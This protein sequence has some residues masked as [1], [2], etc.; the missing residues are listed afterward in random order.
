MIKKKLSMILCSAFIALFLGGEVN[1][2]AY[3]N[4]P[5][6]IKR[7]SLL[8]STSTV[9]NNLSEA[10]KSYIRNQLY[11]LNEEFSLDQF[12]IPYSYDNANK[13]LDTIV[14]TT[15]IEYLYDTQLMYYSYGGYIGKI[16]LKRKY[17][18]QTSLT[19][20]SQFESK[21]NEIINKYIKPEMSDLEKEVV[22]HNYLV[23]N[24]VYDESDPNTAHNAYGALIKGLAVCDGYSKA[25]KYFMDRFGIE[26]G[27]VLS[28][29][30]AHAWNYIKIDGV[31]YFVDTTWDDPVSN[32]AKGYKDNL[33]YFNVTQSKLLEDHVWDTNKYPQAGD[34]RFNYLNTLNV[35]GRFGGK[36]FYYYDRSQNKIWSIDE[37]TGAKKSFSVNGSVDNFYVYNDVIVYGN[38]YGGIRTINTLT[39]ED[40]PLIEG[41]NIY[42]KSI[43]N[44]ILNYES[45][46]GEK[47]LSLI[48]L[49]R[50]N[51]V[52][53]GINSNIDVIYQS[54][55]QNIGWQDEISNGAMSGTEGYSLRV[56]ALK[57][58][59][60]NS[61]PSGLKIKYRTH[62]QNVGWQDWVYD[63]N[64]AGTTGQS[65]RI[66]AVEIKLE[67]TDADKY[68][69]K[70]QAHVQNEG[71]QDWVSD[72]QTAGTTGKSERVEALRVVI[73]KKS[74]VANSSENTL[75]NYSNLSSDLDI[76]YKTHVQNIGWQ[77]YVANGN[78][79]GTEGQSLR[80]EAINVVLGQNAPEGLKLKYKTHVQNIGWQDWVYGGSNSG[81]E[82][83][84]LRLE[85]IQM[86]LEGTDADKYSIQ[87]QVHVENEG[88]LPWVSDGQIGGTIG[89]SQR[90]E[91]IRI[92]IVKK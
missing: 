51:T 76:S 15:E 38:V 92:K 54:H 80:L 64:L 1:V 63:G 61:A 28:Y 40:K 89:K 27:L 50:D 83:Q 35:Y 52:T 7:E 86:Q 62:V 68:T 77:D 87:Y 22:I 16:Q 79:S 24:I 41:S 20:K 36:Y 13:I 6:T 2:Q 12:K 10:A 70:Y 75:N 42:I 34:N 30:M 26:N 55:V 9:N 73:E 78:L 47:T 81:T 85:A 31:S 53:N 8:A 37:V 84:S 60:G 39:G 72:G 32:S 48:S 17:D 91:A 67:G 71:W 19:I 3:E 18:V 4:I 25:F 5:Q 88:W 14:E 43:N 66:E 11:D 65:L 46:N 90:L 29:E 49:N 56:E 58:R 45:P 74:E 21:A 57:I 44:D 69:V 23:N 33:K 59:L 82:G